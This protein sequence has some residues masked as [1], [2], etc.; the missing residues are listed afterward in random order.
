MQTHAIEED[1][2]LTAQKQAALDLIFDAWNEAASEGIESDVFVHTALFV[3]LSELVEVYG[4]TAVS[5][6][7]ARLPDRI[8][9]GEFSVK[10]V[11]Q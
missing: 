2:V 4:E 3:V 9:S 7:A 5:E 11:V 6:F 8:Q 1:E 10:R